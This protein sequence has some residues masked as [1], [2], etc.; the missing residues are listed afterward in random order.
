MSFK[1]ISGRFGK[2]FLQGVLFIT[3][4]T[5][6][7]YV[8]WWLISFVDDLL[9]DYITSF[10]GIR[11]PGLG[12]LIIFIFLTFVG[13]L[14]TSILF[15][16]VV[17]YIDRLISRAPLIKII[18][19]SFKDFLSA[20]V[21][22]DKKFTEPVIVRLSKEA[23]LEKLGF[24]TQKDLTS[25][26]IPEGKVAVYF[27]YSYTVSGNLFIVPADN[28]KPLNVTPT[29]VMKFIVS[30]GVTQVQ[31]KAAKNLPPSLNS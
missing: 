27:P 25:L 31:E 13:F 26:G 24:V 12:L 1:S 18:Y 21:G 11:I 5:M 2:Y 4:L 7:V 10:I 6:T 9:I 30:A 16:P 8:I 17:R 28:V 29:E 22:K 23:E 14:G 15:N 19:T 3:P 20:F